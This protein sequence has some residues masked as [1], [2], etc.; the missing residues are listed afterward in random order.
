MY[1]NLYAKLKKNYLMRSLYLIFFSIVI[2]TFFSFVP[3]DTSLRIIKNNNFARGETYKYSASYGIFTIAESIVKMDKI[4]H[5]VSERPCYKVEIQAHT[6]GLA[7]VFHVHDVWTSYI[8][9]TAILPHKFSRSISENS[10]KLEETVLFD[11]KNRKATVSYDRKNGKTGQTTYD[12]IIQYAQDLVSGYY[13]IR[14]LE[15]DNLKKGDIMSIPA[16]F[17]DKSYDFKVRYVGKE[18]LKTKFGKISA[19]VVTPILPKEQSVFE[20]D[21]A[22]HCWISADVNRVPLK[23]KAKLKVGS[24]T[25][26]LISHEGMKQAF[27]KAS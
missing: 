21:E 18:T 4:I 12:S 7:S 22:I 11:Q 6:T 8:D 3:G 26:E 23:I 16:F 9:T 14:T 10:Y 17:E 1:V 25:L 2:L 27:Q 5:Q 20:G 15:F 19:H 24:F 13:Y